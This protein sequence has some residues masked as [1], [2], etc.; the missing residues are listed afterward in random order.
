MF[1]QQRQDYEGVYN[2]AFAVVESEDAGDK[3]T[4]EHHQN[5][6]KKEFDKLVNMGNDLLSLIPQV[7]SGVDS[8]DKELFD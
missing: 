4:A 7:G 5:L 1:K 3:R 6:L 2:H 8:G